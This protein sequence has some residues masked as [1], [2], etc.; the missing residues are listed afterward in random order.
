M[1]CSGAALINP[2]TAVVPLAEC[3]FSNLIGS[4]LWLLANVPLN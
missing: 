4:H 2:A 1:A 3:R